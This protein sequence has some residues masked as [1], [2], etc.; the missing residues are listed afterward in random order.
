GGG[1]AAARSSK[2]RRSLLLWHRGINIFKTPRPRGKEQHNPLLL[3]VSVLPRTET[4]RR[5]ERAASRPRSTEGAGQI[6]AHVAVAAR[7]P[8]LACVWYRLKTLQLFPALTDEPIGKLRGILDSASGWDPHRASRTRKRRL[9]W[10]LSFHDHYPQPA[11]KTMA[12][13]TAQS[14]GASSLTGSLSSGD[15]WMVGSGASGGGNGG[16]ASLSTT[17]SKKTLESLSSSVYEEL[18]HFRRAHRALIKNR[19]ATKS[20]NNQYRKAS[21]SSST[22]PSTRLSKS[23]NTSDDNSSSRS[24]QRKKR[25]KKSP[26][27]SGLAKL[28]L[29]ASSF[30]WKHGKPCIRGFQRVRMLPTE[31]KEQLQ[32]ALHIYLRPAEGAAVA[33]H[34]DLD[35]VGS[36]NGECFV[37]WFLQA[38]LES[39][40]ERLRAQATQ[41]RE[42]EALCREREREE[43]AR[44]RDANTALVEVDFSEQDRAAALLLLG[45]VALSYHDQRTGHEAAQRDFACALAPLAFRLQ[46]FRSFGVRLT[47]CQFAALFDLMDINRD[48]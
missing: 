40:E 21:L 1:T 16:G 27:E 7:R 36:V 37:R 44:Q 35:K 32:M 2:G 20:A 31:F 34:F 8:S 11:P 45:K 3:L 29:C 28:T 43:V 6:A 24:R 42:Q 25:K 33:D 41:T 9:P 47:D 17:T 14:D 10:H 19:M 23:A 22:K 12:A 30:A 18:Q 4:A 48:R 46:L 5:Q 13:A 38:G 15:L 39:R 26:L